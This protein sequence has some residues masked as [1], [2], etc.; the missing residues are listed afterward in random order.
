MTIS[1]VPRLDQPGRII[2]PCY[3]Y[4]EINI[5]PDE[6][7]GPD[8]RLNIIDG[9]QEKYVVIDFK[10]GHLRLRARGCSGLI[11]LTERITLQVRPR[12]P[13]RN[14]THIVNMCGRT[15][16]AIPALRRYE[17]SDDTGEWL[18]DVMAD[19]LL[20][21]FDIITSNGLLRRYHRTVESGSYLHG[22]LDATDTMLRFAS[23]G[24]THHAQF[25]WFE[26]SIDN[27][28]NRCLK[29][30]LLALHQ[31]Y[32]A[33]A[34]YSA[35]FEEQ[36]GTRI[37][38]T[39]AALQI[40][41]EVPI[42]DR[43]SFLEDPQVRGLTPLPEPRAYYRPALDLAFA[44]L[45]DR[46]ITLNSRD[47]RVEDRPGNPIMS[48]LLVNTEALFEEFVRLSLQEAFANV[49]GLAVLDGNKDPGRKMIYQELTDKQHECLPDSAIPITK[50][51]ENMTPDI[52]FQHEDGT[53]PLIADVKCTKVH[54]YM[55]R[56]ELE[57]VMTY[58]HRYRSPMVMTIHPRTQE[59]QP[60]LFVEGRVGTTLALQYRV[61]LDAEDLDEEMQTM[62]SQIRELISA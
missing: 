8:G 58:G 37:R 18:V 33:Q 45:T 56:S 12:F 34:Q 49:P 5:D 25:S 21:A 30:T 1:P 47:A 11:P 59:S 3:E 22:H 9:I 14:L 61:D 51:S 44:I 62:A 6:V 7:L 20:D 57:Q 16:I 2:I 43:R 40:L 27:P 46:G 60:G 36:R 19:A 4:D 54:D 48:T 55:E 31:R 13:I 39:G 41:K 24:I 26:R 32:A 29:A 23:R 50:R 52:V 38:R 53:Y 15:P 42:T 10:H 35:Q 17:P 28:P